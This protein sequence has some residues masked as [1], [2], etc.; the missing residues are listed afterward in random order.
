MEVEHSNTLMQVQANKGGY[1]SYMGCGSA[2][3]RT[4]SLLSTYAWKSSALSHS[5]TT[6]FNLERRAIGPTQQALHTVT[7]ADT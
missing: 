5:F 4:L 1:N 6:F 7:Q 3:S 2:P